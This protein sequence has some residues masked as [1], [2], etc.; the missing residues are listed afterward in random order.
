MK[1]NHPSCPVHETID[2]LPE[3]LELIDCR[4]QQIYNHDP[5]TLPYRS[6]QLDLHK[7]TVCATAHIDAYFNHVLR[8]REHIHHTHIATGLGRTSVYNHNQEYKNLRRAERLS[9]I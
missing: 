8:C 2:L 6:V 4:L 1:T 7:L 9:K 5:Q 3:V